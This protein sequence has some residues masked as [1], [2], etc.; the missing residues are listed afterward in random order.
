MR[1]G[2]AV[3]SPSAGSWPGVYRWVTAR[4]V[5]LLVRTRSPPAQAR[6]PPTGVLDAVDPPSSSKKKKAGAVSS[7]CQFLRSLGRRGCWLVS[8]RGEG[9]TFV[10]RVDKDRVAVLELAGE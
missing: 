2:L 8:P 3:R 6:R 10:A 1:S 7:A 9:Q 4:S 5:S